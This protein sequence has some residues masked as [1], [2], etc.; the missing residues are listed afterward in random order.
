M[1]AHLPRDLSWSVSLLLNLGP[2]MLT[3]CVKELG[4]SPLCL[5]ISHY[6]FNISCRIRS[7]FFLRRFEPH[8]PY[9]VD[10]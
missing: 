2:S 10:E 3:L 7:D 8:E 5:S 9:V 4:D 6:R 1:G